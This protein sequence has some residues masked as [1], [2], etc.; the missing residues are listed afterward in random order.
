MRKGRIYYVTFFLLIGVWT[1]R[2]DAKSLERILRM[3]DA[4]VLAHV[5][6]LRSDVD[7]YNAPVQLVALQINE[8]IVGALADATITLSVEVGIIYDGPPVPQ[9]DYGEDI[10]L[11]LRKK[12][13]GDWKVVGNAFGKFRINGSN[14]ESSTTSV[15]EFKNQIRNVVA[16]AL[17]KIDWPHGSAGAEDHGSAEGDVKLNGEFSLIDNAICPNCYGPVSGTITLR[18]NA[19]NAQD[20]NGN[21]LSFADVRAAVERA[22]DTWN[23]APNSYAT[24]TVSSSEYTGARGYNNDISTV[25]FESTISNGGTWTFSQSQVIDEVDVI[26]NSDLR[27]NTGVSYPGTYTTYNNPYYPEEPFSQIGPV[28]LEDVAAHELGHGVGLGHIT[29]PSY[30][31]HPTDYEENEWWE[32]TFRRSLE[33]G[34]NSGKVYQDPSASISLS[35]TLPFSLLYAAPPNFDLSVNVPNDLTIAAGQTFRT[36]NGDQATFA[37]ADDVSLTVNGTLDATD[38]TF[39]A[40]DDSW[41]GIQFNSGSDGDLSNCDILHVASGSANIAIYDASPTIEDCTIDEWEGASYGILVSGSNAAPRINDNDITVDGGVGI[42]FTNY[43]EVNNCDDNI[44]RVPSGGSAI[45]V[46]DQAAVTSL[47]W[48]KLGGGYYPLYVTNATATIH[49]SYWCN[50]LSWNHITATYYSTVDADWNYFPDGTAHV[51]SWLTR[52]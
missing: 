11:C 17:A 40:S 47:D 9:F 37:F 50:P 2:L 5:T 7:Q 34:D 32:K 18:I 49:Y 27:W 52:L 12:T 13:P 35:G 39:T 16:S 24:F 41:D 6:E 38:A 43:A 51:T 31:M 48:N 10:I 20:E 26:F 36:E 45:V 30:T 29:D 1:S 46:L 25:T 14:I 19:D 21:P 8:V 23:D 42:Q 3:A 33:D 44:I 4:V 15:Q 22:V 28:D